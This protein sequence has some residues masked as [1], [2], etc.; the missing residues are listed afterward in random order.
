MKKITLTLLLLPMLAFAEAGELTVGE[1]TV[2]YDSSKRVE[3]GVLY[4]SGGELVASEHGVVMFLYQNNEAVLEAHDISGNGEFD[5][6]LTLNSEGGVSRV[7]GEGS[8]QLE[9]KKTVELSDL[10][11]EG[12]AGSEASGPPEDLVGP[13]DSITVSSYQDYRLYIITVIFIVLAYWW[14]RRKKNGDEE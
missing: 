6:F 13:L 5:T 1:Q 4:Y 10:M 2:L 11:A 14:H 3:S 8:G 7:S 12:G 9:R